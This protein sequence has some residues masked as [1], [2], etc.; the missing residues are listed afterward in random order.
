MLKIVHSFILKPEI[1]NNISKQILDSWM[2]LYNRVSHIKNSSV[3]V[4]DR[5]WHASNVNEVLTHYKNQ[6]VDYLILNWFGVYC[7]N[8]GYWHND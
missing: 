3:H 7:Q 6:D 2:L 5:M 1:K 8:F 4:H